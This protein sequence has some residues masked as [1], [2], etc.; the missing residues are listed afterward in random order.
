MLAARLQYLADP[1][2]VLATET[3]LRQARRHM[4]IKAA[5]PMSITGQPT[6]INIYTINELATR[7]PFPTSARPHGRFVGRDRE[8]TTLHELFDQAKE[9]RGQV[10]VVVGEAGMGKSRLLYEFHRNLSNNQATYLEG[11]CLPYGHTITWGA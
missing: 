5:G 9:G 3:T 2:A 10:V 8:L 6:S 11:H 7:R 4:R 1:D